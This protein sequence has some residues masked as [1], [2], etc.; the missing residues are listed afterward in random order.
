MPYTLCTLSTHIDCMVSCPGT[1]RTHSDYMVYMVVPKSDDR[2]LY[3][4]CERCVSAYTYEKGQYR[5]HKRRNDTHTYE[6]TR[7]K[8]NVQTQLHA[9]IYEIINHKKSDGS[10]CVWALVWRSKSITIK[11]RREKIRELRRCGVRGTRKRTKEQNIILCC[12][13]VHSQYSL[14]VNM[15][16]T[17]SHTYTH[18][19]PDS[20]HESIERTHSHTLVAVLKK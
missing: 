18:T 12:Y 14:N 8:I 7:V 17:L 1:Y 11:K 2:I 13:S 9:T 16:A 6:L 19:Y 20:T 10:L 15:C 3:A 5:T 4:V